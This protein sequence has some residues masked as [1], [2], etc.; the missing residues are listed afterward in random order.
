M[1]AASVERT[2]GL[3][4]G[5][6]ESIEK[7]QAKANDSRVVL[8]KRMDDIVDELSDVKAD[9]AIVKPQI[10]DAVTVTNDVKKWRLMGLGALG[11]VGIG[12]TAFGVSIA[13][14]FEWVTRLFSR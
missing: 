4:L 8:H 14:S 5:K 11:V 3:I 13:S 1:T 6:L 7:E 2:L 12:G 10:A 9:F